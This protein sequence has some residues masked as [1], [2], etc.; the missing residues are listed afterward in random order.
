MTY[1]SHLNKLANSKL[2]K[3]DLK[4]IQNK[5]DEHA[6]GFTFPKEMK[7]I[8]GEILF[9]RPSD[10]KQ[11]FKSKISLNEDYEVLFPTEQMRKGTWRVK[12][13]WE[14]D[15]KPFYKEVNIQI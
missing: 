15:N 6:P 5:Q 11:D 1:Q 2:L 8:K 4:I 12:V 3:S 7:S 9:Y 13:N 14:G 10:N